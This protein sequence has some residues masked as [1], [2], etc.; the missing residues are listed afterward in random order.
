MS[1][2]FDRAAVAAAVSVVLAFGLVAVTAAASPN[3]DT[4]DTT[5]TVAPSSAAQLACPGSSAGDGATAEL[6]A[7][8][9]PGG[10]SDEGSGSGQL[11]VSA[12]SGGDPVPLAHTKQRG[13][14][15]THRWGRQA[16][17]SV[18]VE[19]SR[20][21]AAGAYAALQ[22][23]LDTSKRAGLAVA[24]C[25][26]TA[27]DW[28]YTGVDT[29]VGSTAR[30][31]LS[32]PTPA[33]AVVD[34]SFYG[35]KGHVAAVGATGVPIAPRSQQS[36][37][38]ARFA[39]GLDALTMHVRSTRGRVAAAVEVSRI[40]GVT[41]AGD[42][43][44]ASSQP[45]ATDIVVNAGDSGKGK[46]RLVLTNPS[47]REALV[48]VDVLG[49]SGPF[50]PKGLTSL[51]IKPGHTVVKDVSKA[52]GSAAAALHLTSGTAVTAA[53][54]SESAKPPVEFSTASSSPV[55]DD[56]AVV[57]LFAGS[58]CSLTFATAERDGATLGIQPYDDQ[59]APLGTS[60]QVALKAR[61]SRTWTGT[62][63]HDAAYVVVTVTDGT[64]VHGVATYHG[65]AGQSAIPIV[66]GTWTVTRPAVHAAG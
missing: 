59:G 6:M 7:V 11:T 46:Q 13:E 55:L 29:S 52:T 14:V 41:S 3:P 49:G 36:L 58:R 26:P 12:L 37:D 42:E 1:R 18:R 8:A 19:A 10:Q 4:L 25:E 24:R 51:R 43:W 22:T 23:V 47:G 64:Q 40:N 44:I 39:P 53:L 34:L 62:A 57:P 15:L 17:P 38:L 61:T 5:S 65:H 35:P 30:L 20:P 31:V 48:S 66:S 33:V 63:P 16:Q 21:M 45:P 27:D 2:R 56:P 9:P 32:N 50:T 28:W 54:V 60:G